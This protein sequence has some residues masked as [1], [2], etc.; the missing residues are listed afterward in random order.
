M[1]TF[2]LGSVSQT[3]VALQNRFLLNSF[4]PFSSKNSWE[5]ANSETPNFDRAISMSLAEQNIFEK[6]SPGLSFSKKI[7]SEKAFSHNFL[8]AFLAE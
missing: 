5:T 7:H 2:N 4:A 8:E 3:F 1:P 6:L